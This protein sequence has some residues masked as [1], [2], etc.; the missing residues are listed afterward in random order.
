M[1]RVSVLVF[2]GSLA[3]GQGRSIVVVVERNSG[4]SGLGKGFGR[5]LALL[6]L[7]MRII[8]HRFF[9]GVFSV[10]NTSL[11]VLALDNITDTLMRG[12][13]RQLL[14]KEDERGIDVTLSTLWQQ[15]S[16]TATHQSSPFFVKEE[17]I[18]SGCL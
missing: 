16:Y 7:E 5:I 6:V 8:T 17:C 10:L 9:L 12:H 13:I 11:L 1:D 18:P 2:T 15:Y 4:Q 3:S 14:I